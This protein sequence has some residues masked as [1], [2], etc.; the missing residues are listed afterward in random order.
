V[1]LALFDR[2]VQDGRLT[3]VEPSGRAHCFGSGTPEVTWSLRRPDAMRRILRNPSLEL[4]ETYMAGAWDV[5]E[6]TLTDL[7]RV[8]RTNLSAVL[9][10]PML[11]ALSR[12]VTS[13]NRIRASRRNV[14][15]HY[16]LDEAMFRAFLDR[17]MHY[18]CAYFARPG[19][20][21]EEAQQAKCEHVARKLQPQSSDSVLDI[22]SG[23]GSLGLYLA[24]HHGV[25]VTGLTLSKEQH[26]VAAAEAIRRGLDNQVRFLLED[27]RQHAASYDRIVSVGMFEHVGR[28]FMTTFFK[29]V[30]EA[31][32]TEGVALLHSIAS[33]APPTPTNSWIRRHIFPGGYIPSHSEVL[34]AVERA[35]LVTTDLE[36]LRDHYALT[37]AEWNKRFQ[38]RREVFA[39]SQGEAF[40]RMWEFYL[41][42][43]QTAF[44]CRD[45]VVMQ[46]QLGHRGVALP[47]TRDYLYSPN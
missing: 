14:A 21:L 18:S 20:T 5:T 39:A 31:L 16:D 25:T 30:K 27:Y 8:L 6:G 40:C 3:I 26:R 45:L 42:A 43:S 47:I 33:T 24:A 13:W 23:W 11:P 34:A 28:R 2:Y 22:G 37:L 35:G 7:L 32:H 36:V 10:S 9:R 29:K 46:L 4:G 38:A 44:E 41:V 12:L 19:M 17:D 1:H 15:H